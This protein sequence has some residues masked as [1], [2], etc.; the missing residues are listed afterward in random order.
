[1]KQILFFLMFL[2]IS[3]VVQ[4]QSSDTK[5][6]QF[7]LS[8]GIKML[9]PKYFSYEENISPGAVPMI[10]GGALWQWRKFQLGGEFSYID[11]K[12]NT[13]EFGTI[14]TGINFNFLAGYNHRLSRKISVGLQSGF[15]YSLYHLSYTDISYIGSPNLNTAIYHN[16]IYTVPLLV[17]VHRRSENGMITGLR[18]GYNFNVGPGAWRYIEAS[19]TETFKTGNEG[20]FFQLVVGGLLKSN[21]N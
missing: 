13:Q 2:T 6:L 1:M 3:S 15:G 11:G 20:L 9:K 17:N 7:Y 12:K 5:Q 21:R 16:M 8:G 19:T 10:G 18:V 4:A 14:L